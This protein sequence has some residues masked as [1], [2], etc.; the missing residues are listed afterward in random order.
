MVQCGYTSVT[1]NIRLEKEQEWTER[2]RLSFLEEWAD[3]VLKEQAGSEQ[4]KEAGCLG[5]GGA[6]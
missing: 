1:V 3:L 6:G 4:A 5:R 2:V